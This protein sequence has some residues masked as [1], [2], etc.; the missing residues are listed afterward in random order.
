MVYSGLAFWPLSPFAFATFI[1][2]VNDGFE[3]VAQLVAMAA[4]TQQR[5]RWSFGLWDIQ[6]ALL[7]KP[8]EADFALLKLQAKHGHE[9]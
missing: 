3:I 9:V 2:F 8:A 7:M 5:Y 4:P 6:S 1:A